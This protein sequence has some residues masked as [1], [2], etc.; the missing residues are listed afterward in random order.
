MTD[1][2]PKLS[3]AINPLAIQ[4]V[5]VEPD[6]LMTSG[7]ILEPLEKIEK[8]DLD[9]N[10]KSIGILNRAIKTVVE[11]IV[12]NEIKDPE[13]GARWASSW[14]SMVFFK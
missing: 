1:D 3:E 14:M 8:M 4:T 11:K 10:L 7:S 6:D 9:S 13:K 2:I 5:L 12:L